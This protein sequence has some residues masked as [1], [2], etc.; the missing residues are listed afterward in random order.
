MRFLPGRVPPVPPVLADAGLALAVAAV[1]SVALSA[2]LP[3]DSPARPAD[4]LAHTLVLLLCGPL[5]L[6]RR[7][8]RATV[9][10]VVGFAVLVLVVGY[11]QANTGFAILVAVFSLGRHVDLRRALPVLLAVPLELVAEAALSRESASPTD[12]VNA[13]LVIVGA[14]W[15]GANIRRWRLDLARQAVADERL[16]I[17]RELH[18]VVA[19][20]MSVVAVQS[21]V[22]RHVLDTRPEQARIALDVIASTSRRSLEELRRMLEVLRPGDPDGQLAPAPGLAGLTDL[23]EQM[24]RAG[25]RVTVKTSGE[26]AELPAGVDLTA[27]RIVQ[28]ALT[29]TFKHAGVGSHADVLIEYWPERLAVQVTDDGRGEPTAAATGSGAGLIGMRERVN[30]FGGD[31]HVG[32]RRER[33][34]RVRADLP[35]AAGPALPA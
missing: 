12:L 5:V 6:R 17:A 33:G 8:P 21:G 11:T 25:V 9:L 23:A 18:D 22:A 13:A 20:G 4:A 32:P 29:N 30:L 2:P 34:W 3:A 16:R 31:L 14:F 7:F 24:G 26:P 19:H 28:E 35:L 27:Y 15:L 10:A 1:C